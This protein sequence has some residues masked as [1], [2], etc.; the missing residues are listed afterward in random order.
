MTVT[1]AEQVSLLLTLGMISGLHSQKRSQLLRSC[2]TIRAED[3][4]QTSA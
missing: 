2:L 4:P 3:H 1:A